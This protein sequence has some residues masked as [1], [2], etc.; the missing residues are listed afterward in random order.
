MMTLAWGG[1]YTEFVQSTMSVDQ[2]VITGGGLGLG[3]HIQIALGL[4]S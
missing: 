2:L 1:Q 4:R 3:G